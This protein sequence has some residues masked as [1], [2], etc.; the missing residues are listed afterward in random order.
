MKSIKAIIVAGGLA[1]IL[2]L[3]AAFIDMHQEKKIKTLQKPINGK[4]FAVVE[5]F[6]S[7]GCSSCPPA[8][9][10]VEKIQRDNKNDQLYILS[11][12]VDYWDHQGWKDRFSDHEFSLRQRQYASWLN[13]RTVYTPQIVVN[14]T[15]EYVGSDQSSIL[16]A[17]STGLKQ[18]A[19]T[20]LILK[21]KLE[22][23]KV[24]I[25]YDGAGTEKN[26]ELVLA[27]VEKSAKSIV[28]AGENTGRSLSHV[29]VVRGM[30]RFPITQDKKDVIM[31]LPDDFKEK[32]WEFIG[33]VQHL[34]DGRIATAARFDF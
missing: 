6:T 18:Q 33:F 24:H 16:N 12:H 20:T 30:R 27:L 34:S 7:E 29:Q 1:G 2:F 23:G 32:G 3:T 21:G 25:Q 5:L 31:H 22:P 15:T 8:D 9:E 10:L 14:G 11:F 28:K 13:L 4:G 17:I 19:A 26:T